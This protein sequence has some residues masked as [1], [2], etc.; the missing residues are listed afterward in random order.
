M[1]IQLPRDWSQVTLKQFQA[2]QALLRDEG[3]VYQKNSE[4]ISILS[5]MDVME[6]QRLSL[7]SYAAVMKTLEFISQPMENRLTR[8]FK[9]DG[10]RYRVVS[11]IYQLNGGQYITLQHL[12]KDPK[13]VTDN[14][15]Q[16]MAIFVI[17]FERKWW[18]WKRKDYDSSKHEEIAQ[19]M[20][21]CPVSIIHPLSG[22]FLDNWKMFERHTLE[23]SVKEVKKAE[24]TLIK[25][26]R[27]IKPNTAGWLP[28]I[29]SV[30]TMLRNGVFSSTLNSAS[31][32]ILSLSK[33]QSK[34]T[35]TSK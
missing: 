33:K 24:R 6:V 27:R 11:D 12:L 3:D 23:S 32:S 17:P 21:D 22:F 15:H 18:G 5:G 20:L 9:L 34:P 25:E 35:T 14:L 31:F 8:R 1:K 13:K 28:S 29:P 7:K 30:I 26:L 19:A 16:I 2:I 4:I 10:L